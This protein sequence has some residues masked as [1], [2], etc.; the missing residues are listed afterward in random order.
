[1]PVPRATERAAK[2]RK[3]LD[4]ANYRYHVLD[5]PQI[6]DADYDALLRELI[7][8]ETA[9][10]ELRTPDSP[11]VR[12]GSAVASGFTP[13]VHG[14]PMLSLGNAFDGDELRAF[15][16]R[17][18]KLAG[19]VDVAY[20]CELKIDGLATSLHYVDGAFVRGGTRGDGSVGEDVTE[21]LRTVRSI[22]LTLRGSA[23]RAIDVRGEVY[24]RRSDFDALNAR[25]EA[26]GLAL[27]ANPRNTAAGALRQ[28]D[29]RLTAE[30]RLSFFAYAVGEVDADQPP[31]TQFEL[32]AFLRAHGF[33][34]NP[35]VARV[36]TIDAVIAYTSAGTPR[37]TRSTTRSTASSSRSTTS[38]YKKNSA[39]P[40][41]I[42]AGRSP[43]SSARAKRRRGCCVS[44]S[45][46][47]A[48][49][50]S[51]RTPS[52]SRCRSAA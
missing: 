21:N 48:P 49:A 37:A 26:A 34:T 38:R 9:H 15:D 43:T 2:L 3:L 42:R 28:L 31:A 13:Y 24:F 29:P 22:P 46:S 36:A 11:T 52:S 40:A 27:F 45:T 17:V 44:A 18:R 41:R 4:D 23:V 16:E 20:T 35:H 5:D 39:V 8:L 33:A 47:A 51:T 6:A 7:D 10:P 25:R 12:V 1:M 32:L 50:R 19:G 30:R 14:K